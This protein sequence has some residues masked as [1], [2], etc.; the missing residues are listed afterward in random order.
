[1]ARRSQYPSRDWKIYANTSNFVP[2]PGDIAV[3]T[4]GSAGHTAIVIGPSDKSNFKCIDQNW[5]N[6]NSYYGS[7]AAYVNHDYSGRGGNLYFI[8][9]PYKEEPKDTKP[10]NDKGDVS[11]DRPKPKTK[12]NHLK[13]KIITVTAEDD[14]KV[15]YPRFIP[16]ESLMEN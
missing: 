5:Y 4:Y 9:P 13:R 8:R 16:T 11:S 1:M 14:E 7:K 6:A 2:K 10:S 3:W 12:K 15:E